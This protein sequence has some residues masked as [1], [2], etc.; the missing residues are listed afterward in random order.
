MI[1]KLSGVFFFY[2]LSVLWC[3]IRTKWQVGFSRIEDMEGD[4]I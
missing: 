2:Q 1:Y 4:G 3:I